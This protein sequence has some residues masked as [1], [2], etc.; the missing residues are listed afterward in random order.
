MI[1]TVTLNP[2]LD[3]VLRA[4][5]LNQDDITRANSAELFPGGKGINVS[6][7]LSS[8]NV[9]NRALGFV[10][11]FTGA[12][13]RQMLQAQ[14]IET[15]FIVLPKGS[16]RIN[17]KL[18]AP[19]ELAVNAPGPEVGPECLEELLAKLDGLESGDTLVLAGAVPS[20]M[21]E[22]IYE[23]IMDHLKDKGIRIVVDTTGEALRRVLP[24]HPFLVKPNHHELG[25]L[26]DTEIDK[27]DVDRLAEYA[28]KL[29]EEGAVNVLVSRGSAGA[30]LVDETG[31][32]YTQEIVP[33]SAGTVV[34]SVGCGDSMVAG[35]LAGYEL[36]HSYDAALRM[37]SA[38]GNA[39]AFFDGIADGKT[40]RQIYQDYFQS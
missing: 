15:D 11:G 40:I 14:N 8:L 24:Y 6:M 35:F 10:A 22:N 3:Y 9:P 12:G 29:Q 36:E 37:G 7:L 21:P 17:V 30:L 4:E 28:K 34:N 5:S 1:Y 33:E 26:F 23:T 31:A 39:S 25:E 20:G 19:G 38:A 32:V 16:T 13:L 2:A 27:N 18:Y